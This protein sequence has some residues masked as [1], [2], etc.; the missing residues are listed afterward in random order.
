MIFYEGASPPIIIVGAG[1]SGTKLLRSILACAPEVVA[2]PREINYIWRHG[3]LGFPTDELRPEHARPEVRAFIRKQFLKRGQAQGGKRVLEKTCANTLRLD[4]VRSVFPEA[5]IIHLIRDGRAVTE[6]ACRRWR[7]RPDLRYLLEKARWA[8]L[9]DVPYYALRYLRYQSGRLKANNTG[10]QSSWGPR[11][12]GLDQLVAEKELVEVCAI[13]WRVCVQTAEASI[14]RWPV[15]EA[16]T[17]RYEDLV[18]DPVGVARRV[19][20]HAQL[21]FTDDCAAFADEY[22]RADNIEKWRNHLSEAEVSLILPHIETELR[23]HGY[24]V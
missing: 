5:Y 4:F 12:S 16:L 18:D 7:A 23:Q 3:N 11:F 15:G 9:R 20:Q 19:Y 21:T 8:P 1:R 24:T 14:Q 13:Q 2:F 10:A 6:S 17:L 22:V